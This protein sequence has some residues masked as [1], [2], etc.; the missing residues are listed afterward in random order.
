[1]ETFAQCRTSASRALSW[2]HLQARAG[3][4]VG[5]GGSEELGGRGHWMEI[6]FDFASERPVLDCRTA[7]SLPVAVA[8]SGVAGVACGVLLRRIRH[9]ADRQ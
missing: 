5:G 2:P 1:M 4:V 3:A 7:R 6:P 9:L 8:R